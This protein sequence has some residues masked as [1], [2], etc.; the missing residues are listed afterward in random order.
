MHVTY[1]LPCNVVGD[2]V[3]KLKISGAE[4]HSLNHLRFGLETLKLILV[5]MPCNSVNYLFH[6][7][8]YNAEHVRRLVVSY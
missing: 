3:I 5:C 6:I 4:E 7:D 1:P 2:R 8:T